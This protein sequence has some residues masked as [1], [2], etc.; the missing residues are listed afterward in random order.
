LS[1]ACA[2]WQFQFLI[3]QRDRKSGDLDAKSYHVGLNQLL[4]AAAKLADLAEKRGEVMPSQVQIMFKLDSPAIV[5]AVPPVGM[6]GD[7]IDV[8]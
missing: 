1:D 7:V 2:L 6:C 3:L 4:T 5:D 8:A